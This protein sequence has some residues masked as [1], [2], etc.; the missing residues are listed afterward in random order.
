MSSAAGSPGAGARALRRVGALTAGEIVN[1]L[2]RFAAAV[3]LARELSLADFGLLNV[4]IAIGGLIFLAAGMGLTEI[5]TRDVSVAPERAGELADRV[6]GGRLLAVAVL[7]GLTVGVVALAEP[8]SVPLV[9]IAGLMAAAVASEVDW[10][11]RG[12]ERMAA[13]AVAFASGGVLVLAGAVLVVPL[14]PTAEM[15][16]GVFVAGEATV[17]VLTIAMSRLGRLPRPR[18]SGLRATL[19]RSWPLGASALIVY[20]YYANLDT[21]LLSLT[22]SAEE[23]GL[24]SAPYRLFLSFNII[25]T[26]AAYAIL[27]ALSRAVER[28][29]EAD[30]AAMESLRSALPAL[31]GYGLLVLGATELAGGRVLELLFGERFGS[32]EAV[33]AVLCAAIPWYTV[34]FPVGYALI[35]RD[36]NRRFMVGAAIAGALNLA[37]NAAL[38]PPFGTEGAAVATT[39]A[40]IAGSLAWL[41]AHGMLDVRTA[42]LVAAMALASAGAFATLEWDVAVPVGIVTSALGLVALLQV[43]RLRRLAT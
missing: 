9:A 40:L 43:G 25:G 19:R 8:G 1:K 10:L 26:F 5:G 30:R 13:T 20:S 4:G 39:A 12:Q 11:L 21:V 16:L 38:I 31:A 15:A 37:L 33:F 41:R 18:L 7:S 17:A 36:A 27:P 3:V 29:P 2:A 23:A 32:Q 28:G 6:V 22:R 42:P 34:A 14:E 24:Y 35:A